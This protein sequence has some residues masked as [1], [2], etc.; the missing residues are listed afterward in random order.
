MKIIPSGMWVSGKQLMLMAN[1]GGSLE[2]VSG[3]LLSYDSDTA[4]KAVTQGTGGLTGFTIEGLQ[5]V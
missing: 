1:H 3:I 5:Q 4:V 2:N